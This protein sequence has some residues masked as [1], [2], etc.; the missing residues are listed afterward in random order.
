M[1]I[2]QVAVT[3]DFSTVYGAGHGKLIVWSLIE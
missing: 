1:H 3:D 2:H